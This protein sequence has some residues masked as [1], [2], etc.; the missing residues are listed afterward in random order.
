MTKE[1]LVSKLTAAVGDTPYGKELV[2]EAE[3][4]FGDS[5]QKYG[6]DMK[7]RLDLRLAILKAYAKIDKTF[8][9]E[10]RETAEEDKIAIID[11]ALKAIE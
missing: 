5:E 11:K 8:G 7:D 10:A 6:W 1:E 3:K 2:A 4:T 9:K